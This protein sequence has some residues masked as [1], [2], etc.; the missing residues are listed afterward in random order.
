MP[1]QHEYLSNN[2][3]SQNNI[4]DP[5][6]NVNPYTN[7]ELNNKSYLDEDSAQSENSNDLSVD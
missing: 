6:K 7:K 5:F 1:N 2:E 4:M 3:N